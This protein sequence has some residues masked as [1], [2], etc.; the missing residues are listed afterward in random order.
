MCPRGSG[1][2]LGVFRGQTCRRTGL[3]CEE[4][5]MAGPPRGMDTSSS[6]RTTKGLLLRW[7]DDGRGDVGLGWE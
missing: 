2:S 5:V 4:P 7:C 6:L 1:R 3:R